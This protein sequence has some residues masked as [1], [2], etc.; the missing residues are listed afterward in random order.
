MCLGNLGCCIV[1]VPPDH[2]KQK[3]LNADSG[4]GISPL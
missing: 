4:K 2:A 1:M 3:E